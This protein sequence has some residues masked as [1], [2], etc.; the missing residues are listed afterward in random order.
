VVTRSY[1]TPRDIT[2]NAYVEALRAADAHDVALLMAFVR[3]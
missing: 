2:R 3:S 1:T